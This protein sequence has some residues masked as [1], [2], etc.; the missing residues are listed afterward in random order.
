MITN[1][2]NVRVELDNFRSYANLTIVTFWVK[3]REKKFNSAL[4]LLVASTKDETFEKQMSTVLGTRMISTVVYWRESFPTT[5]NVSNV[6]DSRSSERIS[7][8][9]SLQILLYSTRHDFTP[10][11]SNL[12]F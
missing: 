2:S 1:T 6:Q 5:Y 11:H 12:F 7:I 4:P 9:Q 10:L 8:G 3:L